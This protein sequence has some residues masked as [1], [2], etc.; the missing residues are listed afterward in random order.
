[1]RDSLKYK[2]ALRNYN[3][4]GLAQSNCKFGSQ[5]YLGVTWHSNVSPVGTTGNRPVR[6]CRE[7]CARGVSVLGAEG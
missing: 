5:N 6:A 2:T 1:M 3:A 7:F 4:H